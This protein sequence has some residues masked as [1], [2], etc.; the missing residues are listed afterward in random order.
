VQALVFVMIVARV[1]KSVFF[2]QLRAAE[3]EVLAHDRGKSLTQFLS[4][5]WS[6]VVGTR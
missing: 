1:L 6:S 4:S 3:T 2:G 5:I